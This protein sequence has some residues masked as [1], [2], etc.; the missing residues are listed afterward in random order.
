MTRLLNPC[1]WLDNKPV[2]FVST[3]DTTEIVH[4][5]RKSGGN[6]L[7]IVVYG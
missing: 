6:L 5:K 2:H 1:Q 7:D 3:A 4:V